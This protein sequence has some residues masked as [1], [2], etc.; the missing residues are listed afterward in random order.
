M[1]KG[2]PGRELW[3]ET[4][5]SRQGDRR[6]RR[7]SN[8]DRLNQQTNNRGA[9]RDATRS[10]AQRHPLRLDF[11]SLDGELHQPRFL[12]F[13][14]PNIA[15]FREEYYKRQNVNF[16]S[17]KKL[18]YDGKECYFGLNFGTLAKDALLINLMKLGEEK[19][20]TLAILILRSAR[21]QNVFRGGF[22]SRT[23]DSHPKFG[24]RRSKFDHASQ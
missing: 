21:M 20:R 24:F 18:I 11:P 1:I 16:T 7:T 5:D 13:V 22:Q 3:R 6:R 14:P 9:T 4:S 2:V 8:R 23:E 12:P 10:R 15:S 17:D 19:M